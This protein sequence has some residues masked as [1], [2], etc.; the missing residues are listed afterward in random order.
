MQ[1]LQIAC[2]DRGK[3]IGRTVVT[4]MRPMPDMVV[5]NN[6]AAPLMWGDEEH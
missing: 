4:L 5:N 3:R 2:K 1:V 6:G